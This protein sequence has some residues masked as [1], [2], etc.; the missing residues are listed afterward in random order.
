VIG[1]SVVPVAGVTEGL[2]SAFGA[3]ATGAAK[4]TVSRAALMMAEAAER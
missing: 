4:R 3:A 2:L 1:V